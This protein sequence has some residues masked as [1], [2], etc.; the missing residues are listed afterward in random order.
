MA[1][2]ILTSVE[3]LVLGA[4]S[5]STGSILIDS[6]IGGVTG[7]LL[8][9]EKCQARYAVGGAVATGLGGLLGLLGTVAF[10]YAAKSDKGSSKKRRR[11]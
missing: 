11:R 9:P 2:A 1:S 5:Q 10:I 7:Y 3:P 4:I 6:A 8:A